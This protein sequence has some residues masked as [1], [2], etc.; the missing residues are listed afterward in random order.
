MGAADGQ[1]G[2]QRGLR[3]LFSVI[4]FT[5][6]DAGED[7]E[8][9]SL[10]AAPGRGRRQHWWAAGAT[11]GRVASLPSVRCDASPGPVRVASLP[12]LCCDASP[13]PVH[14][15]SVL[16]ILRSLILIKLVTYFLKSYN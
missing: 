15:D 13:G 9:V 7:P 2:V 8:P 6:R 4:K 16:S 12:S 3:C 11:R 1:A 10:S 5:G 14:R